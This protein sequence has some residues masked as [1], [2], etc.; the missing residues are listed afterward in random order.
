MAVDQYALTSL[1]SVK[2]YLGISGSDDDSLLESLIDAVSDRIE[3]FCNRQFSSRDYRQWFDGRRETR[4]VVQH[5]PITAVKRLAYGSKDALSVQG[6]TTTDLRAT[7]E[8]QDS[9]IVLSRFASDGTETETE[10]TFASNATASDLQSTIDGTT[11]WSA[12][13]INNWISDDLHRI[14]GQDALGRD[15]FLSYA[16]VSDIEYRVNEDTGEIEITLNNEWAWPEATGASTFPKGFQNI[17]V[18]YTGGYATIPDD[19]DQIAIEMTAAAFKGRKVN[20]KL[21]SETIGSYSY[22]L[23]S[24]VQIADDLMARLSHWRDI[25]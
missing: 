7:V 16:D 13:L 4:F 15:V 21:Q 12:T 1:A 3:T 2:T 19:L 25:R 11:G 8:V 6:T 14:G 20:P 18:H 22:A 10:V 23:A 24:Q 5:Y 17:F 9:Q